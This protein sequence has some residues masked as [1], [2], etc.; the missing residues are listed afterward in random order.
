[1]EIFSL[2]RIMSYRILFLSKNILH[3]PHPQ[4][5]PSSKMESRKR[6]H[7]FYE[8]DCNH[9]GS[10]IPS[11][12]KRKNVSVSTPTSSGKKFRQ[13]NLTKRFQNEKVCKII[14]AN[15]K[16]IAP[17]N[18][19]SLPTNENDAMNDTRHNESLGIGDPLENISNQ[20]LSCIS[21]HV[22]LSNL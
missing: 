15:E 7:E 19:T 16:S 17:L 3:S 11:S 12:K 2:S 6:F 18:E 13:K 4:P 1:M 21:D 9:D 14:F 5:L 8:S 22:V 10:P 20:K